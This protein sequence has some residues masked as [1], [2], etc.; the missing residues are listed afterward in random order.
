[1]G[2]L[3]GL[4]L[5]VSGH[6]MIR[7]FR[8]VLFFMIIALPSYAQKPQL[9]QTMQQS[10]F[11]WNKVKFS[12]MQQYRFETS[13]FKTVDARFGLLA[14]KSLSETWDAE[15]HYLWINQRSPDETL[16]QHKH[17]L[18]LELNPH[19]KI[20]KNIELRF[21]NRYELIKE[22]REH[23]LVQKFRQR[24]ELLYKPDIDWLKSIAI[25]TEIFYNITSNKVDEYRFIPMELTFPVQ[26]E[27]RYKLYTLIRWRD[28]STGWHPQFVLGSTLE[29]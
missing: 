18:E 24:Q 11:E 17:R 25:N 14:K 26:K 13:D 28:S 2:I 4:S 22:E 6:L 16:F 29:W 27:H 8:L 7:T 15:I 19:F 3:F 12:F 21:R 5:Y 20:C 23:K 1:M 10:L 9:W